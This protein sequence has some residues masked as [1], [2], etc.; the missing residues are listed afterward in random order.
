MGDVIFVTI[1]GK[2]NFLTVVDLKPPVKLLYVFEKIE[3]L[4]V[5]RKLDLILLLINMK[6][7][8]FV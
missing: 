7:F 1:S 2:E 8:M 3:N 4:K 6:D 5:F